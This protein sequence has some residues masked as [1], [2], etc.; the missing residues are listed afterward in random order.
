LGYNKLVAMTRAEINYPSL[1]K[2]AVNE[3]YHGW[4]SFERGFKLLSKIAF[5][6][7]IRVSRFLIAQTLAHTYQEIDFLEETSHDSPPATDDDRTF[8]QQF[9]RWSAPALG[10]LNKE[11]LDYIK[12]RRGQIDIG[13]FILPDVGLQTTDELQI[14]VAQWKEEGREIGVFHGGFDP[15]TIYHLAIATYINNLLPNME[16][17]IGFDNDNSLRRKG[18]ERPTFSLDRRRTIF[19]AFP[20]VAATFVLSAHN[21]TDIEA[22]AADYKR[23]QADKIFMTYEEITP[24][25]TENSLRRVEAIRL[26]GAEVVLLP[27]RLPNS[28]TEIMDYLKGRR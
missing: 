4:F 23:L 19:G 6:E 21:Y 9:L 18:D 27:G 15:P 14:Q 5:R 25:A 26:G 16:L 17:L 12:T 20:Q 28:A 24:E 10:L 11:D 2:P 3:N 22:Y 13:R 1:P 8:F 7:D